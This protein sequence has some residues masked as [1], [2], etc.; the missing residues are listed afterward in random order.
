MFIKNVYSKDFKYFLKLEDEK[1]IWLISPATVT[2]VH[3]SR[4]TCRILPKEPGH[5]VESQGQEHVRVDRGAGTPE[6][7]DIVD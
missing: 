5:V 4:A 1:N 2:S 6:A 3:V 7:V